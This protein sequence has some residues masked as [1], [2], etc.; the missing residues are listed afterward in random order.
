VPPQTGIYTQEEIMSKRT[1]MLSSDATWYRLQRDNNYEIFFAGLQEYLKRKLKVIKVEGSYTYYSCGV[2]YHHRSIPGWKPFKNF[3]NYCNS[4]GYHHFVVKELIEE[5]LGK[6]I[7][8]EC[9][10]VNDLEVMKRARLKR[11][12]GGIDFGGDGREDM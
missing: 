3:I 8:C 11:S 2:D 5:T 7:I 6:E 4:K 9:E 10:I 1:E 12:F